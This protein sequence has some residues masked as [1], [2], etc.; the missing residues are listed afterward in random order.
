MGL[1]VK[2]TSHLSPTEQGTEK[3]LA[4]ES[5]DLIIFDGDITQFENFVKKF[6]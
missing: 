3:Y 6:E 4:T 1:T 5:G 2:P